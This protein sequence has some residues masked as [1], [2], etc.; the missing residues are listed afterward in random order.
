MFLLCEP[1]EAW[2]IYKDGKV[3]TE[4]IYIM[5]PNSKFKNNHIFITAMVNLVL[6]I[7]TTRE[8]MDDLYIEFHDDKIK[9]WKEVSKRDKFEN[10]NCYRISSTSGKEGF[11]AVFSVIRDYRSICQEECAPCCTVC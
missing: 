3:M 10:H 5:I 2:G 7:H 4:N 11:P 1:R 9:E 6:K 8:L